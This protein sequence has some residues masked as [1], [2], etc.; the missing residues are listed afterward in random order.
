MPAQELTC[1]QLV[2][3]VTDY[4]E[5]A[6][7][8]PERARFEAHLA[9]YGTWTNVPQYGRVWSP[10]RAVVEAGWDPEKVR[11]K[12]ISRTDAAHDSDAGQVDG[13]LVGCAGQT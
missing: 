1:Q 3:L 13:G 10:S 12:G 11:R 6:L 5:G 7:S 2:E 4:L 8:A 9:P